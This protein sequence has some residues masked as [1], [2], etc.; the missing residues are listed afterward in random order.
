MYYNPNA[1]SVEPVGVL[2]IRTP[3]VTR[4]Q[5]WNW[6]VRAVLPGAG[7]ADWRE[8]RREGEAVEYQA[9]TVS[10]ELHG[11]EAEAYQHGLQSQVPSI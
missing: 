5:K 11:A 9:A 2:L 4:W 1:H 7:H 10:L 6:K 8:L 3:G